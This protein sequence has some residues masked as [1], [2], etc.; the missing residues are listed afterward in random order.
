EIIEFQIALV[1][2][3]DKALLRIPNII[4]E[5]GNSR[6]IQISILVKITG[7]RFVSPIQRVKES[8]LERSLT[9][10]QI[11]INTMVLFKNRRFIGIVTGYINQVVVTIT[12][13][14]R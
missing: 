14:I 11:N 13:K 8:L 6:N 10:I 3:I 7:Y 12:V 9:I 5:K 2:Q 4:W 1:F